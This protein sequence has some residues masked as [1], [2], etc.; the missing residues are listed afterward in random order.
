[1][2]EI[3]PGL[4]TAYVTRRFQNTAV[5]ILNRSSGDRASLGAGYDN[6]SGAGLI[7]AQDALAAIGPDLIGVW[8]PSTRSFLLDSNG[9][10]T[11]DGT[12]GSDTLTAPFGVST[13]L[14]VTGD[15]NG[16]GKDEIGVWRPS[17]RKFLLDSNGS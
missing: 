11:W 6:D 7:N 16:D 10:Y 4:D 14:P 17:T 15:W 9:S 12:A 5:D 8:R 2:R 1:M 13:D 3:I